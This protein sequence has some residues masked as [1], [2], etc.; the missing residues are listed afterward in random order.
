MLL[1]KCLKDKAIKTKAYDLKT[2][3]EFKKLLTIGSKYAT[4]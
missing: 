1:Y 3:K 4:I 2:K